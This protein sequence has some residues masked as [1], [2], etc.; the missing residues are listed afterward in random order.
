M[1]KLLLLLTLLISTT[2][3]SQCVIDGTTVTGTTKAKTVK[4]CDV[5]VQSLTNGIVKSSGDSLKTAIPGVDY[6]SPSIVSDSLD[7]Y[8]KKK[9]EAGNNSINSNLRTLNSI[10]GSSEVDWQNGYL[11]GGK[12]RWISGELWNTS[13]Y[14][15]IDFENT[16]FYTSYGGVVQVDVTTNSIYDN[17]TGYI[18]IHWANRI[19]YDK[20]SIE[21][22]N[23][24]LRIFK[25]SLGGSIANHF[26][27]GNGITYYS[28][29]TYT[30][31]TLVDKRY[32]DSALPIKGTYSTTGVATTTFT[33]TIGVTL[34]DTLYVPFIVPQN[35]LT[36]VPYYVTNL[37]TGSFDVNVSTGLT[38]AVAFKWGII[39]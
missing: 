3:F 15:T 35:A 12:V 20:K 18:S 34:S 26:I 24:D 10:S 23:Y 1:K 27:P 30:D 4:S 38:G 19:F 31:S 33:V 13:N 17:L 9:D 39:K 14:R 2:A 29:P 11:G 25:D 36:A 32:V 37:T 7:N 8:V 16:R 21:A 5:V 28:T 22:Y 6:S